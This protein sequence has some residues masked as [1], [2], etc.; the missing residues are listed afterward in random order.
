MT[1]G[2]M[3]RRF[4]E[5]GNKTREQISWSSPPAK[6]PIVIAIV[7]MRLWVIAEAQ[8]CSSTQKCICSI[9]YK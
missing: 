3:I 5:D 1:M 4:S 2:K 7:L 6:I 8:S 9:Q